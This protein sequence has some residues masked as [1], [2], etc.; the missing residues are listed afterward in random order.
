M[1]ATSMSPV[2]LAA[3]ALVH[4]SSAWPLVMESG[5]SH[6]SSATRQLQWKSSGLDT[7][8]ILAIIFSMMI[9]LIV[10]LLVFHFL[11][12]RKRS[13]EEEELN[14]AVP[15]S[16]MW[17]PPESTPDGMEMKAVS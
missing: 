2:I 12:W 14:P 7:G 13:E 6:V 5:P 11:G 1:G 8:V 10:G 3:A 15:R 9:F 16:T 4:L 17:P